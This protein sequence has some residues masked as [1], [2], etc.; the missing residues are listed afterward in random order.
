MNAPLGTW[1]SAAYTPAENLFNIYYSR[2][3]I[4][5]HWLR[6]TVASA[7]VGRLCSTATPSKQFHLRNILRS[8]LVFHVA[9]FVCRTFAEHRTNV[10]RSSLLPCTARSTSVF[11]LCVWERCMWQFYVSARLKTYQPYAKTERMEWRKLDSSTKATGE[12]NLIYWWA[13]LNFLFMK[14]C[15]DKCILFI[16]RNRTH[17]YLFKFTQA[18]ARVLSTF[19]CSFAFCRFVSNEVDIISIFSIR[20]CAS[21][22]SEAHNLCRLQNTT[23]FIFFPPI[24]G[25]RSQMVVPLTATDYINMYWHNMWWEW[26]GRHKFLLCVE[27]SWRHMF[28]LFSADGAYVMIRDHDSNK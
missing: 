2:M 22:P 12:S 17:I 3:H 18:Q 5:F 27:C 8:L 24:N 16:E 20:H 28:P 1:I 7:V 14:Y 11:V 9:D 26:W 10:F 4:N 21:R 19:L 15:A 6:S 23:Y 25:I 13:K